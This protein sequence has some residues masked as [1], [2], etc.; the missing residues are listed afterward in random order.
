MTHDTSKPALMRST[1]NLY[2]VA[3]YRQRRLF[4]ATGSPTTRIPK[5]HPQPHPA[6]AP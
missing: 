5:A 6:E 1:Q 2:H 4:T 3:P